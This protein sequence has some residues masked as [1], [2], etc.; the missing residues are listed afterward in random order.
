[1]AIEQ[2]LQAAEETKWTFTQGLPW[3]TI[4]Q[5]WRAT[6]RLGGI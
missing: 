3:L 5:I 2:D 1:M 6:A 4:I